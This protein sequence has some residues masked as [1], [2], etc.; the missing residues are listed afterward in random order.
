MEL[1]PPPQQLFADSA[2]VTG[3]CNYLRFQ[4]EPN[5][6]IALAARIKRQAKISLATKRSSALRNIQLERKRPTNVF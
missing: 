5:P 4:L 6:A 3:R 1:K 2:P